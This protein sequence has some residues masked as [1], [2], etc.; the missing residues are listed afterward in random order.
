MILFSSN[1]TWSFRHVIIRSCY[2]KSRWYYNLI[3]NLPRRALQINVGFLL[4]APPGYS[5]DIHFNFPQFK[6]E[7]DLIV[8][9]F[10]GVAR[11]SRTPQGILVQCEFTSHMEIECGRCATQF[12]H[13]LN[14]EFTDLYAFNNRST[15]ESDLILPDDAN[16]PLESLI[17]EY[18]LIE[19]PIAY[20]CKPDCK[21]LCTE[22]GTDLNL[23]TCEHVLEQSA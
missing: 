19:V 10:A 7:E 16:I 8:D 12:I 3:V 6:V 2:Y 11:V 21:G 20:L 17:R 5:R 14:I 13:P 9:E 22:C 18:F 23:S 15:T 1:L 4:N